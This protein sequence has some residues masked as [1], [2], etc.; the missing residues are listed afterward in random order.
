MF[1][2]TALRGDVKNY[3]IT[4]EVPEDAARADP[5]PGRLSRRPDW[6]VASKPGHLL[7]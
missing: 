4:F 3:A 7:P 5:Q 2:L 1:V 6:R